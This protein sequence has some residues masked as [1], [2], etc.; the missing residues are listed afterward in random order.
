[1]TV[2][3]VAYQ[4]AHR[5]QA[6]NFH[7]KPT[8]L[9]F[10]LRSVPFLVS[11]QGFTIWQG[12]TCLCVQFPV[13]AMPS[14]VLAPGDSQNMSVYRCDAIAPFVTPQPCIERQRI[15]AI[16]PTR[17]FHVVKMRKNAANLSELCNNFGIAAAK[18]QNEDTAAGAVLRSNRNIEFFDCCSMAQVYPCLLADWNI[19]GACLDML[20]TFWT[21]STM[22]IRP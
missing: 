18:G 8:G 14:V 13:S 5:L 3:H 19:Y 4:T 15:K 17:K 6:E 1:M 16:V 9:S 21:N 20:L 11:V 22:L 2:S 10:S 7:R 12:R